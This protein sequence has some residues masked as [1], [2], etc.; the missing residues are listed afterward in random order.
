[1]YVS[2]KFEFLFSTPRAFTVLQ[3]VLNLYVQI[4]RILVI[5]TWM[6]VDMDL[7]PWIDDQGVI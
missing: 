1:M 7:I 3:T 5:G 4:S 6:Q 2:P